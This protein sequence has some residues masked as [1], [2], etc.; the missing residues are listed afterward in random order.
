[1]LNSANQYDFTN[2]PANIATGRDFSYGDCPRLEQWLWL[3][4]AMRTV[5][6]RG[7]FLPDAGAA[8]YTDYGGKVDAFAMWPKLLTSKEWANR[9][10]AVANEPTMS[11]AQTG[12]L[13]QFTTR[14]DRYHDDPFVAVLSRDNVRSLMSQDPHNEPQVDFNICPHQGDGQRVSRLFAYYCR[15]GIARSNLVAIHDAMDGHSSAFGLQNVV[16]TQ[17]SWQCN[18]GASDRPENEWN[19]KTR[20]GNALQGD[21]T[22]AVPFLGYDN[23][24]VDNVYTPVHPA[25]FYY[26]VKHS[27]RPEID[28]GGGAATVPAIPACDKTYSYEPYS[29]SYSIAAGPWTHTSMLPET[30]WRSSVS[31][32]PIYAAYAT[33]L[34]RCSCGVPSLDTPIH[35][36]IIVNT[37]FYVLPM[38]S[39]FGSLWIERDGQNTTVTLD[40]TVKGIGD[41]VCAGI[42]IENNIRSIG[43]HD[44]VP[45]PVTKIGY[46]VYVEPVWALLRGTPTARDIG[47]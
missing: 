9:V 44:N 46:A 37:F 39:P 29:L 12:Y 23:N 47:E 15:S 40:G 36:D 19:T 3:H 35:P 1:M 16:P 42:G 11:F 10:V 21:Y 20:V 30:R 5:E 34:W 25:S 32:M 22:N 38:S 8:V 18:G 6:A 13:S 27:G 31:V 2:C 41:S 4:E 43:P 33:A 17:G 7:S 26:R 24:A 14:K 28:I 45:D